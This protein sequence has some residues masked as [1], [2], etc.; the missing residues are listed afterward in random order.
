MVICET[1]KK[2]AEKI[3]GNQKNNYI[4]MKNTLNDFIY[5]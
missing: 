3:V 2:K 5:E 4:C 1:N